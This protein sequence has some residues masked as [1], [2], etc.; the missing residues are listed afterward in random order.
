MSG[1]TPDV[2]PDE[3]AELLSAMLD[4]AVTDQER[5]LAQEWLDRSPAA[6]AEYES[7]AA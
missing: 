5:A 7:L 3:V 1:P 2:L 4:G 6:R